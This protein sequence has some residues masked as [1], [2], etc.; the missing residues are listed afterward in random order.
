MKRRNFIKNTALASG[1]FYMPSFIKASELLDL[2]TAGYKRLVVVQLSGGNDGLNTVVPFENDIYYRERP[3]LNIP[4]TE[5]LKLNDNLGLHPNLRPLKMLY[6]KGY[7]SIINNVGYPNPNR[8][9]F[10]STDIWHSASDSNEYLSSGWLGRYLDKV[11]KNPHMGIEID[12]HLTMVLKGDKSNGMAVQNPQMLFSNTQDRFFKQLLKKKQDAH[13]G[14]HNLGYLYKTLIAAEQSAS[15]I[16]NTSKVYQSSLE[17]PNNPLAAQLKTAAQFINSGLE[18]KVMYTSLGGFDTHFGQVVRQ[19]RL[20]KIYAESMEVFVNDLI[21][22]D[23]FKDTLILTFSEFGRRVKQ[24]AAQGTD[25]GTANNVF[26]IGEN[27]KK[28]GLYNEGP[29]LTKLDKNGDLI[30]SVDFRRIYA[31]ILN[32]W[33]D[34]DSNSILN[35][36]FKP[37]RFI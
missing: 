22:N 15:Y 35:R 19:N 32:K 36:P 24:N 3:K 12:D 37:L 7:L 34:V 25:H 30:Y 28:A 9:H 17:Y 5:V 8:S 1:L 14:E 2:N 26:V 6:D 27:L 16:Y 31:T 20:L 4:K 33:L 11:G 18:C 23:T 29:D 13:L 21:K 10:R